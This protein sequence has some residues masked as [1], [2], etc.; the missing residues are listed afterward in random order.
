M[1]LVFINAVICGQRIALLLVPVV[2]VILL[3]LT[4]Q[5]ANL[6]RFLPI[7]VGLGVVIAIGAAL[8]P[9]VLQERI[10]SAIDR[11]NAS[12]PTEFIAGQAEFTS[13][14]TAGI[15]GQGVGTATSS[16]RIF[17]DTLLIETFYP[18]LLYEIGPLGVLAFLALVTTI[19]F[20]TFKAYRL[21]KEKNLRSFGASFWVFIL[22]ISYNTYWYPL[23][24]DPV[25][26]YYWFLAGV[27]LKLPE[28]DQE[29]REKLAAKTV[30]LDKNKLRRQ[31]KQI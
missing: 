10:N 1:A 25:A 18:K 14:G 28:I 8:F 21:V 13:K 15:F 11:W 19:V 2:T 16:T 4:G 26:I 30:V 29:E 24:T 20:L 22:V 6:R 5:I 7:A 17:G 27:I 12:P 9:E 31:R 23:D 3:V